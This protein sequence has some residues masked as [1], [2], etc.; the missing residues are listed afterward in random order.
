MSLQ[1]ILTDSVASELRALYEEGQFQRVVATFESLREQVTADDNNHAAALQIAAQAYSRIGDFSA[2][3]QAFLSAA[4]I[5]TATKSPA[6][7]LCMR[8]AFA[9]L[10]RLSHNA[11]TEWVA[12]RSLSLPRECG[13]DVELLRYAVAGAVKRGDL[14]AATCIIAAASLYGATRTIALETLLDMAFQ[15][16]KYGARDAP[17]AAIDTYVAAG[18]PKLSII[19]C[20][21]D[22]ARYRRF[23]GECE[24]ALCSSH[25][26]IIRI[27]DAKSMCEGY[28]RGT[29]AATGELFLYCHDDIEFITNGVHR[30]LINA[31]ADFDV[32]CCVGSSVVDGPTWMCRD[33]TQ[34]QGWM[35][36]S[37]ARSGVYSMSLIGVPSRQSLLAAGD[38]CFI[39]CRDVI[40]QSLRWDEATFDSFH[41]YDIDFCLRARN[42]GF[43]LGVARGVAI[44]HLSQGS[45]DAV[46]REQAQRFMQKHGLPPAPEAV[47]QWISIHVGTRADAARVAR[48]LM[49]WVPADIQWQL[50]AM[51]A[52]YFDAACCEFPALATFQASMAELAL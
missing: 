38:G 34:S 52:D 12:L 33:A 3:A 31:L 39:A 11:A 45:F 41:L 51:L 15:P 22:D 10:Q 37:D 4:A 42:S 14:N 25:F 29:N 16:V 50:R 28:N 23:V 49:H 18:D 26:E 24:R 43:R 44:N 5:H 27:A 47:N 35:A 17:I 9:A 19:V 48:N 21:R 1:R 36:A 6:A 46:W 30:A 20:S 40:A 32:A 8:N 7:S 2:S 13:G